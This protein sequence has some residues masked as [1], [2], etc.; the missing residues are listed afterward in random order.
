MPYETVVVRTPAELAAVLA[1]FGVKVELWGLAEAKSLD[2]LHEEIEEGETVLCQDEEGRL[3][4]LVSA[5]RADVLYRTATG[6]ILILRED[7]QVFADGRIRRRSFGASLAEKMKPGEKP[8]AA[9][10]RGIREELGVEGTLDLVT[11]GESVE[12]RDSPSYPGLS[13]IYRFY[14]FTATLRDEQYSPEGYVERQTSKTSY[15]IW[16]PMPAASGS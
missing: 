15:F 14:K 5:V 10:E 7:R 4:R 1:R 6:A 11:R 9:I 3:A 13:S 2:D 8:A 16:D 12:R